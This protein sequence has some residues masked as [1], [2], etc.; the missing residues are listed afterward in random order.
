MHFTSTS[1]LMKMHT[2]PWLIY[3][4][5]PGYGLTLLYGAPETG[6]S[7]IAIDWA[8]CVATGHAWRD[9]PTRSGHVAYI[10]SEGGEGIRKRVAAWMD[11]HDVKDVPN[12]QWLLDTFDFS[13]ENKVADFI[14]NLEKCYPGRLTHVGDGEFVTIGGLALELIVVD[15]LACNFGAKDE[16]SFEAMQTFITALQEFSRNTGATILLVHHTNALGTRE[17]G[18]S[19]LRGAVNVSYTTT[20]QRDESNRITD[21][22]L[23]NDKQKDDPRHK[24]LV[25]TPRVYP[26]PMLPTDEQGEV[27]S[28]LLL[29]PKMG[30]DVGVVKAIVAVVRKSRAST[31]YADITREL[32]HIEEKDLRRGLKMAC[33][34]GLLRVAYVGAHGKKYYRAVDPQ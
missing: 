33:A 32:P 10:A 14:V 16:N 6:K 24:N 30:K 23:T 11:V 2:P 3:K 19:S 17:R 4:V 26:L 31:P 34:E 15:T 21:V 29:E 22:F 18:H 8:L 20:C 25:F 12:I 27:P 7:F 5:L 9:F 1:D 28:T 13:N